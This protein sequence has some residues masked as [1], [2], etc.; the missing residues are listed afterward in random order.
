MNLNIPPAFVGL[1]PLVAWSVTILTIVVHVAF[2]IGVWK[3]GSN[4]EAKHGKTHLTTFQ[5]WAAAT[6]I[7][8]VFVGGL[9]YFLHHSKIFEE[10]T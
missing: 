1:A 8:G 5:V 2:A 9:Y 6:L 7:G 10:Q 3:D 4:F